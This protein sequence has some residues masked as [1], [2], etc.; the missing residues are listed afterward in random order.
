ME[1]RLPPGEFKRGAERCNLRVRSSRSTGSP[2]LALWLAGAPMKGGGCRP[3]WPPQ[4]CP[5]PRLWTGGATT[6]SVV[7]AAAASTRGKRQRDA[8]VTR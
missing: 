4:A 8:A 3:R 7:A 5:S 2:L 1:R 6:A